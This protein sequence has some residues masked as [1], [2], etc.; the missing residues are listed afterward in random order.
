MELC[1]LIYKHA[2]LL[3]DTERYGLSGQLRK[4]AVSI[5]SNIA[6]GHARGTSAEIR[7]YVSISQGSLAEIETQIIV[8]ERLGVMTNTGELFKRIEMLRKML[9]RFHQH[10]VE[11]NSPAYGT[12]PTSSDDIV[13]DDADPTDEN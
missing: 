4:A 13:L 10:F 3:P 11:V 7:R 8:A 1:V 12:P 6:K 9:Y 2:E 5:P